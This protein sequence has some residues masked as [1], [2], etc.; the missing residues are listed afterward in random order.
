[1]ER[2]FI[3]IAIIGVIIAVIFAIII[4]LLTKRKDNI[5]DTEFQGSFEKI[6]DALGGIANIIFAINEHQRVTVTL[7]NPKL[8]VQEELKALNL[9]AFIINKDIKLLFK[10][11]ARAFV[12]YIKEKK[13]DTL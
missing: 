12:L 10:T 5:E 2:L 13:G 6:L 9:S 3:M 8:I 4:L 1:M 11:H 7:V